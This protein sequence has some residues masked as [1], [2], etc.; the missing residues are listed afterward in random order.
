MASENGLE[1]R[2]EAVLFAMG[3]SV[4]IMQLCEALKE[5]EAEIRAAAEELRSRYENAGSGIK[6]LELDGAYQL[7]TKPEFYEDL[8]SIAKHPK[9]P[10]LTDTLMETLSVI[11]YRQPVTK[12]DIEKIRGVS[13]D[14]AVNRL[15][16]F[17]LVKEVGRV[18]AP[19]RPIL[20]GTT[21]EFLR[22]FGFSSLDDMPQMDPVKEEDIKA[23]A[24][25]EITV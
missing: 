1:A 10:V 3:N 15:I 22:R 7:V 4:E 11:A 21:E 6:L 14:H 12:A 17:E 25:V 8:V 5:S 19:G 23:E 16:E 9:K 20:F 24:E 2:I 18:N 13:S